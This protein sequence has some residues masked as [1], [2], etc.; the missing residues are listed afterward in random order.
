MASV[1]ALPP[2]TKHLK[3]ASVRHDRCP[4]PDF[5]A[6]TLWCYATPP[7]TIHFFMYNRVARPTDGKSD[8]EDTTAHDFADTGILLMG[9]SGLCH[10]WFGR[11]TGRGWVLGCYRDT[12]ALEA[13]VGS[14][15]LWGMRGDC[16]VILVRSSQFATL[17]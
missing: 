4:D 6:D 15:S 14:P 16:I 10:K 5:D 12:E 7:Y 8:D 17:G 1:V 11:L 13:S 3:P 9:V 2:R